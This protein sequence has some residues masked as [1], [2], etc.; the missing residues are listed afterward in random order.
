MYCKN[1][2][3]QMEENSSFC[4]HCGMENVPETGK[5][6]QQ[7]ITDSFS[8]ENPM[9]GDRLHTLSVEYSMPAGTLANLA[10]KRLVEDID[11]V[12]GLRA[13]KIKTK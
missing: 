9:L 8:I 5:E 10:V 6:K 7:A 12:R 1:C 3:K 4:P 2:G 11:F 13:G